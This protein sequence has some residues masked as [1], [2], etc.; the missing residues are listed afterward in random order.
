[1]GGAAKILDATNNRLRELAGIDSLANLQRLILA[2]N[3]L[4]ELPASIGSLQH[5]KAS[6]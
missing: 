6:P 2:R 3:Q 5:L 4:S 1:M